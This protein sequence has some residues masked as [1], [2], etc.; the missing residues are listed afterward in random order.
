MSPIRGSILQI[1]TSHEGRY[2]QS[3]E[4]GLAILKAF[5]PARPWMGIAE[6]AETLEMSRPTTHRYASTLVALNYLEQGPGRKYRLGMRAGD[7]GRSAVGSTGLRKLPHECLAD[8][9]DRSAC[10]ASLAVLDGGDIVYI[11]RARSAWHGQSEVDA[12]LGRGSR[13]PAIGTAMGRTLLAQLSEQEQREAIEATVGDLDGREAFPT[14]DKLLDELEHIREKGFA[15]ADQMH[16]DGQRCVAAPVRSRST[17][18]IA[19]VDVAAPKATFS[20]TQVRERLVPLV[21]ES[22]ARM[23]AHLGY[24]H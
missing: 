2:S 21:V 9:R 7:P 4:R 20:R 17:E 13:L 23:S 15:I 5:T 6:L 11:D 22:A 8:L 3:L 14:R 1:P 19:A 18:V 10:T 12:R 24:T 16:V